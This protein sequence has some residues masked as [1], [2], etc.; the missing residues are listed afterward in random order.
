[1]I[2]TFLQKLRE[3]PSLLKEEYP[4]IIK[5]LH[6]STDKKGQGTGNMPTKQESCFAKE[7]FNHGFMFLNNNEVP[8]ENGAYLKYQPNGTQKSIDFVLIEK[9]DD[10]IKSFDFDLKH[11]NTKSFFWNDGWFENGVIYVISYTVKKIDRLYIGF[12]HETPTPKD[13]ED[14]DRMVQFKKK[15]NSENKDDGFLKKYVRFANRYSC[16]QFTDD[17]TSARWQSVQSRL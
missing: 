4:D 7:A 10:V 9:V 12:G 1:M 6:E 14:M 17:F 2:Q 15:W 8:M 16:D 11:T 3:F 5:L 13:T